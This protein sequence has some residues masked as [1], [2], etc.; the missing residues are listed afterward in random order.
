MYDLGVD[1]GPLEAFAGT[2]EEYYRNLADRLA[3]AD[4]GVLAEDRMYM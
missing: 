1:A 4:D 2:V 3:A